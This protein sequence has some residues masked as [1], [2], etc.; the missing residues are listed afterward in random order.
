MSK[1]NE[2]AAFDPARDRLVAA[3][4]D[5]VAQGRAENKPVSL[6]VVRAAVHPKSAAQNWSEL[7]RGLLGPEE[8]IVDLGATELAVIALGATSAAAGETALRIVTH[9]LDDPPLL[10]GAASFP[11][12]ADSAIALHAAAREAAER[13]DLDAPVQVAPPITPRGEATQKD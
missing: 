8:R 2:P 12:A 10:C 9:D 13:A 5:A 1:S 3:L 7:V 11:E 6:I 4:G